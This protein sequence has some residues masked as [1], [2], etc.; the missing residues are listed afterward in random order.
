MSIILSCCILWRCS[1]VD[2]KKLKRKVCMM[3]KIFAFFLFI[4][5]ASA[6]APK[7]KSIPY[8]GFAGDCVHK[9]LVLHEACKVGYTENIIAAW[10]DSSGNMV[11]DMLPID[12]QRIITKRYYDLQY[13]RYV[14]GCVKKNMP[15][16][17]ADSLHGFMGVSGNKSLLKMPITN[18]SACMP[19]IVL[20]RDLHHNLSEDIVNMLIKKYCYNKSAP[21]LMQNFN[22]LPLHNPQDSSEISALVASNSMI[23]YGTAKG[24]IGCVTLKKDAFYA[25][26]IVLPC[27]KKV[28]AIKILP[29]SISVFTEFNKYTY[30]NNQQLKTTLPTQLIHM[31]EGVEIFKRENDFFVYFEQNMNYIP[32]IPECYLIFAYEMVG[33]CLVYAGRTGKF[34]NNNYIH[35]WSENNQPITYQNAH[36]GI[37]INALCAWN[38]NQFFSAGTDGAIHFWEIDKDNNSITKLR[39]LYHN[40]YE[41]FSSLAK[42]NSNVLLAGGLKLYAFN[43]DVENIYYKVVSEQQTTSISVIS[44]EIFCTGNDH[45]EVQLYKMS[46]KEYNKIWNSCSLGHLWLLEREYKQQSAQDQNSKNSYCSFQ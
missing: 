35:V 32:F 8:D 22:I 30:D 9:E 13:N 4:V 25:K 29:D 20:L 31:Q 41:S 40:K 10:S 19:Q 27:K 11:W 39:T 12:L 38:N 45:G 6:M 17:G 24:V 42:L 3:Q 44:S 5:D 28:N 34:S 33:D 7:T 1:Y 21:I 36:R 14:Y 2:Y 26:S 46:E 23:V 16:G 37:A 18:V 43:V 15:I